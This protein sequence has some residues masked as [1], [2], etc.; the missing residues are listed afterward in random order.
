MIISVLNPFFTNDPLACQDL[1]FEL[2][3][4]CLDGNSL[5]VSANNKGNT[6]LNFKSDD[7]FTKKF[8]VVIGGET[9]M[10]FPVNGDVVKVIPF[11]R[12]GTSENDCKGKTEEVSIGRLMKC[13][14]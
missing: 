3:K 7:S 8:E 4:K 12:T 2:I 11:I 10:S 6:K 9:K 1:D 14:N 5:Q 13:S